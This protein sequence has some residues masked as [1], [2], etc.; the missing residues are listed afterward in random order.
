[1]VGNKTAAGGMLH[2]ASLPLRTTPHSQRLEPEDR[3]ITSSRFAGRRVPGVASGTAPLV[4]SASRR[5]REEATPLSTTTS[6]RRM[7]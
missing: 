4:L 1:M 3:R 6:A 7:P 5:E 2:P